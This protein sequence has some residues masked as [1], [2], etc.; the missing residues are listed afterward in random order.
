MHLLG[1]VA[2]DGEN[3]MVFDEGVSDDF[4]RGLIEPVECAIGQHF[5]LV[6]ELIELRSGPLIFLA[7]QL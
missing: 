6:A 1:Y 7:K 5:E 2:I 4:V 3:V